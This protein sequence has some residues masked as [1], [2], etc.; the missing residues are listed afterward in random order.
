[1][2]GGGRPERI[3]VFIAVASIF[4]LAVALVGSGC[5][6]GVPPYAV[7]SPSGSP[8][9]FLPPAGIHPGVTRTVGRIYHYDPA[10]FRLFP[11]ESGT[12]PRFIRRDSVLSI[13][14]AG[15]PGQPIRLRLR[16]DEADP[17]LKTVYETPGLYGFEADV[18]ANSGFRDGRRVSTGAAEYFPT[19]TG[20]LWDFN[21]NSGQWAVVDS[22]GGPSAA[23]LPTATG[24]ATNLTT[25]C[26]V[27]DG[28]RSGRFRPNRYSY[29]T[30]LTVDGD[31]I[32]FHA[33][34]L[35]AERVVLFHRC[36][37]H[38]AIRKRRPNHGF[39]P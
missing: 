22:V 15:N 11:P 38:N 26:E 35:I 24:G 12:E 3:R 30:D 20:D 16:P 36:R 9:D 2:I 27:T 8:E 17:V 29:D 10:R 5:E 39:N 21:Y 19:H 37:F 25:R 18:P 34:R 31:G 4:G 28:T 33:W 23:A 1:M 13:A 32:Q 6:Q 7:I 14:S